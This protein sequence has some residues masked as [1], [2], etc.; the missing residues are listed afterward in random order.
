ML[1]ETYNKFQDEDGCPDSVS[2]LSTL[3]FDGDGISD[4]NDKCPLD[5]ETI[6]GYLDTDGCPD[7]AILDSDGDGIRDE[8]DQCPD[9][10]RNLE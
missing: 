10:C 3:D 6:N 1:K 9:N 7:I 5:S 8:I 2:G 4:L